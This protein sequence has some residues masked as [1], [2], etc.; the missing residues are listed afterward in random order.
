MDRISKTLFMALLCLLSIPAL[1]EDTLPEV[2]HDGL[3][4]VKDTKVRAVWMRPGADLK[5]YDKVAILD[6]YVAFRKNWQRDHNRDAAALGDRVSD[7]DMQNI[8]EHLAAELKKVFTEELSTKGGHEV[9]TTADTGVLILRP[10]II[11]LDVTAPDL[12]EPGITHTFAASTGQMTLYLELYDGRTQ[13]I[14]A[15]VIDPEAARDNQIQWSN[16]VSNK[17]EADRIL[18]RWAQLLN[19]QLAEVKRGG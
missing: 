19:A 13:D 16:S 3:H 18:R 7:G 14:I 10:A 11:N 1:A 15:R 17:A 9:V 12:M 2:S 8:R 4:R 5:Q 6:T